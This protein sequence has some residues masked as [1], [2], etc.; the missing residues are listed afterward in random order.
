MGL[1]IGG[2]TEIGAEGA[3]AIGG[4][5]GGGYPRGQFLVVEHLGLHALLS[6]S[7]GE[8]APWFV[9]TYLSNQAWLATHVCNG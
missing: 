9:M 6:E 1:H 2:S 8:E 4:D 3:L 5:E 7:L